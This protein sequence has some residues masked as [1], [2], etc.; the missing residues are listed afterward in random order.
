MDTFDHLELGIVISSALGGQFGRIAV[1]DEQG[2]P[3]TEQL[4]FFHTDGEFL[5]VMNGKPAFAGHI[6]PFNKLEIEPPCAGARIAFERSRQVGSIRRWTYAAYY[7]RLLGD[8]RP[9]VRVVRVTEIFGASASYAI[10]WEG[11]TIEDL[12]AAYPLS[13]DNGRLLDPLKPQDSG[14]GA[15]MSYYIEELIGDIWVRVCD[16]RPGPLVEE[17]ILV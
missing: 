4:L 7:L 9:L 12:T 14:A 10:P 5:R 6:L 16:P 11:R 13:H 2:N 17:Y 1:L 3:T 15:V 8:L